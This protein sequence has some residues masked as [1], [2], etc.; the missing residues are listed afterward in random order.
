VSGPASRPEPDPRA[1]TLDVSVVVCAHTLDRWDDIAAG[2]DALAHQTVA[3]REVILVIDHNDELLARA[4]AAFPGVRVLP[5]PRTGG[6]SGARNTGIAEAA[7]AVVAFL[8]DDARPE[9]DW[10]ERL[11]SAYDDE[12]VQAVGGVARPVWPVARPRHLP[13]ELDWLVGCTYLGQPTTRADVRNLWGC[14]MSVRAAVFERI[15]AF[16]E[17]IGRVGLIPLGNE[18]TELCIRIGQRIPGA[19]VVFEPTAVV[20]HRVTEARCEWSYLVSRSHAE[21]ISKAAISAT[22]GAGDATSDERGYATRVLPRGFLRE[23]LHLNPAGAAGIVT[24]LFVTAW[25]Y[26]RGRLGHVSAIG[27]SGSSSRA[28][29]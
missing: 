27:A 3:P 10:V 17:E 6:A 13:P 14:N 22:V 16:D 9:A 12:A 28:R 21:G 15:G 23:L 18:E 25:W 8:D 29:A 26:A 24:C 1:G 7:G 4:T 5:N 19:R 11:L 20:H 2:V